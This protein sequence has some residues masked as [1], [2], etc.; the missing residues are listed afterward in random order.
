MRQQ[1]LSE[2]RQQQLIAE[3][4]RR[5][6][7]YGE[8]LRQEEL[9][10][11]KRAAILQQEKRQAQ[12]KYQQRYVEKLREQRRFTDNWRSYDYGRD[13]Y[14]SSAPSYRY[15]YGG[16]YYDIN[17][18]G[19]DLLRESVNNGYQE[20]F[21]AGQADQQDGWNRGYRSSFAYEDANY[22][23]TGLYVDQSQY[24]HYFRQGFSRGYEDGFGNRQRYGRG[25]D[26]GRYQILAS[27]LSQILG[28][29]ALR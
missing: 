6:A 10:A 2:V 28:L 16:R 24:N 26:G 5:S 8:R 15:S 17:Q 25:N 20:G 14:F 19:A 4:Q 1:R 29:R 22:G 18:Y 27:V 3:Q 13:P 7:E 21:L 9:L 12:Y 11:Q 23:Y